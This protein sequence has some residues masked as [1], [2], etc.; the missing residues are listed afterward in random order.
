M[1]QEDDILKPHRR[2]LSHCQEA[3]SNLREGDSPSE[4]PSVAGSG[5]A[6]LPNLKMFNGMVSTM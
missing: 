6:D 2:R 3:G 4:G 1:E 5:S